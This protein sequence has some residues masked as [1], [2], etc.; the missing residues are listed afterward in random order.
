MREAEHRG[1]EKLKIKERRGKREYQHFLKE[2]TTWLSSGIETIYAEPNLEY[3]KMIHC[4]HLHSV[5]LDP[6]SFEQN[7]FWDWLFPHALGVE[8]TRD[9]MPLCLLN[10]QSMV[11]KMLNLDIYIIKSLG[12][13]LILIWSL[14]CM[15]TINNGILLICKWTSTH[16]KMLHEDGPSLTRVLT[17]LFGCWNWWL[18]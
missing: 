14:D 13:I 18:P 16:H 2:E 5:W 10:G 1:K 8:V 9:Q 3:V 7:L 6:V 15:H 12:S 11:S 17:R 4:C